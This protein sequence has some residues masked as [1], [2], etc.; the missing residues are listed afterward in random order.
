M[1]LHKLARSLDVPPSTVLDALRQAGLGARFG[2]PM[3]HVLDDDLPEIFRA[4]EQYIPELVLSPE[5]LELAHGF[6]EEEVHVKARARDATIE[7]HIPQAIPKPVHAPFDVS[8]STFLDQIGEIAGGGSLRTSTRLGYDSGE[9]EVRLLAESVA[10]RRVMARR[11]LAVD[12]LYS[13]YGAFDNTVILDLFLFEVSEP[14]QDD[15]HA[16]DASLILALQGHLKHMFPVNIDEEELAQGLA[17]GASEVTRGLSFE[18]VASRLRFDFNVAEQVGKYS[19]VEAFG[20]EEFQE[21]EQ[22]MRGEVPMNY[23]RL[24]TIYE[25]ERLTMQSALPYELLRSEQALVEMVRTHL[26]D[27][28]DFTLIDLFGSNENSRYACFIVAG[29]QHAIGYVTVR[30]L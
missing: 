25:N 21:L 26:D 17:G 12:T 18:D 9:G 11:R 22:M 7:A 8:W 10:S 15:L 29:A 30:E 19:S 14:L 28:A 16:G 13:E 20:A 27:D 1:R 24:K 5:Q 23:R 2:S 4:C 6:A 3:T